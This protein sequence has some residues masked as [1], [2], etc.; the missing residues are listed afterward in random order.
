MLGTKLKDPND[1][2]D[3]EIDWGAW[4]GT[5]TITATPVVWTVPAGVT[6]VAQS[7]T[8]TKTVVWISGGTVG[9]HY[10]IECRIVTAAGRITDES[11]ELVVR[12]T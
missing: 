1:V 12:Q 4:L 7:Q 9:E 2:L 6:L 3:Y 8:T 10:R 5:D 11:F